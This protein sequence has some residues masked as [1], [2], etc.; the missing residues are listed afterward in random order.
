MRGGFQPNSRVVAQTKSW[1]TKRRSGNQVAFP[2]SNFTEVDAAL[3]AGNKLWQ[4]YQLAS[5]RASIA[6]DSN[7]KYKPS[8]KGLKIILIR[9]AD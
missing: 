5:G 8:N 4:L 9:R 3:K 2:V 1:L 7:H 6:R